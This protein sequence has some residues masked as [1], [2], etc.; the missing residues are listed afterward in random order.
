MFSLWGEIA[1]TPSETWTPKRKVKS[2][3]LFFLDDAKHAASESPYLS[4]SFLHK[5][6]PGLHTN[7][8]ILHEYWSPKQIRN[9]SCRLW[10]GLR[11]HCKDTLL[12][13][14]TGD[15]HDR[16]LPARHAFATA[17][18]S[19]SRHFKPEHLC[20]LNPASAPAAGPRFRPAAA[21]SH[22]PLLRLLPSSSSPP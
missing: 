20:P 10:W 6:C 19:Q 8:K 14:T 18:H 11:L 17:H 12:V 2:R 22:D 5:M 3:R 1:T 16:C 4:T 9:P 13:P 7:I 21:G 15:Y